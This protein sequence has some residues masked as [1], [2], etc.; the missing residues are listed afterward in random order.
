M[1]DRDELCPRQDTCR[2]EFDVV[3]GP[4]DLFNIISINLTI[5]DINDHQ[6][7]FPDTE[8]LTLRV[9]ES[10]AAGTQFQLP[11]AVDMDSPSLGVVR[12]E[13]FPVSVRS[14][15][16][17][18]WRAVSDVRL[19]VAAT[20]LD[21]ETRDRYDVILTA[22]DGGSPPLNG[23]TSVN[24][25]IDDVNDNAPVFERTVYTAHVYENDTAGTSYPCIVRTEC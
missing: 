21:R 20:P 13:L 14:T 25:V 12:Y 4:A 3:V 11:A 5:N 24:I 22:F 16:S 6:P 15:F 7:Q 9:A 23:S 8:P 17:V 2:L 1:L 19:V 18:Q 10:T